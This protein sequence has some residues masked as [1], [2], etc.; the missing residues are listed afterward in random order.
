MYFKFWRTTISKLRL[1]YLAKVFIKIGREIKTFHDK[2]LVGVKAGAATWEM[3][4]EVLENAE[5]R[6]AYQLYNSWAC[7]Q[8]TLVMTSLGCQLDY[9]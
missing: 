6:W 9:I 8:R 3:N 5:S 4:V 7:S 2:M 1:L